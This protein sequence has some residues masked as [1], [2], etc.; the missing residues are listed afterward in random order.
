MP[1][2]KLIKFSGNVREWLP[3]WSQF[4]K[5]HEDVD[6]VKEDKFQYLIQAMTQDLRASNLVKS[7][8]PMAENYD[9]VIQSLKN[10]FGRD[11]L[12]I[13]KYLFEKTCWFIRVLIGTAPFF[14]SCLNS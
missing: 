7:F 1:T 13:V 9:K 3:F 10:R 14:I 4:K 2:I 8:P 5:I 11:D 12:Q 6:I